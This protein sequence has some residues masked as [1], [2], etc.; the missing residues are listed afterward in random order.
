SAVEL[1]AIEGRIRKLNPV[2]QLQTTRQS[3]VELSRILNIKARELGTNFAVPESPA[4]EEH[5]HHDH[6]HAHEHHEEHGHDH[7]HHDER[8][9]SLFMVEERPLELKK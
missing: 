5:E 7:G 1:Q 8:V 2:A 6:E 9:K 4:E 3:Q